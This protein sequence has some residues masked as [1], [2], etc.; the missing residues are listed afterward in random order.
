MNGKQSYAPAEFLQSLKRNELKPPAALRGM[1][2]PAEGDDQSL[3]FVPG[4]S[5]RNWTKIPL[6]LIESVQF[7]RNVPC[8][9]HIHPL[10]VLHL[11][12]PKTDEGRMLLS[13]LQ[14]VASTQKP[15]APG[16]IVRGPQATAGVRPEGTNAPARTHGAWCDTIPEYDVDLAGNVWCLDYCWES[17]QIA[18]FNPC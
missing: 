2:K 8:R 18:V 14:A 9:D 3:M 16:R 15:R 1:V 7:V 13:L 6:A 12:E 4:T 10:V 11:N 5:C 17:E